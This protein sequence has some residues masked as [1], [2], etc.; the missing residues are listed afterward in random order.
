MA[1]S[2]AGVSLFLPTNGQMIVGGGATVL[3]LP[4]EPG[5]ARPPQYLVLSA[6]LRSRFVGEALLGRHADVAM[7]LEPGTMTTSKILAWSAALRAVGDPFVVADVEPGS[8]AERAG[9]TSG[10]V[11]ADADGALFDLEEVA[12]RLATGVPVRLR[13]LDNGIPRDVVL[14][15]DDPEDPFAGLVL[16]GKPASVLP[17][18]GSTSAPSPWLALR[19]DLGTKDV[20]GPSAGL[21]LA[22][23]DVDEMT[24]GD[25]T[26]GK[27]VAATGEITAWGEVL[28]VGGYEQKIRAAVRKGADVI[29]VPATDAEWART[30]APDTVRVIGVSTLVQAVWELC[31]LGGTS[32]LCGNVEPA[33]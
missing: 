13:V 9:L 21:L 24:T 11:L 30:F 4:A 33:P 15:A 23:A 3:E 31:G 26:G 32:S 1:L 12:Q 28:G 8:A 29:L 6:R 5:A 18:P 25:L 27:I 10:D 22:L 16:N 19:P 20:N 17:E 14:T 7:G 2:L